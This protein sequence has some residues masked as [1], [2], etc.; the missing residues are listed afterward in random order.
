MEITIFPWFSYVFSIFLNELTVTC[1]TEA[2]PEPTGIRID[3]LSSGAPMAK[4]T[5]KEMVNIYISME[6]SIF[7]E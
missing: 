4:E 7:N 5:A 2:F 6:I 1:H 3:E